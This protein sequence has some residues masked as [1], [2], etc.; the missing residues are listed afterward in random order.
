MDNK[1]SKSQ[2]KDAKAKIKAYQSN[3][4]IELQKDIRMAFDDFDKG[5][6]DAFELDDII[7]KYLN[8]SKVVLEFVYTHSRHGSNTDLPKLLAII[9]N[10]E[11]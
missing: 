3:M 10:E 5:K 7:S 6:I 2:I 8:R 9:E 1:I 11:K 4:L